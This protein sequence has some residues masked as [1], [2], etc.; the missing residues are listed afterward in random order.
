METLLISIKMVRRYVNV[1]YSL[2]YT[3]LCFV[4]GYFQLCFRTSPKKNCQAG[5]KLH[6][7][8]RADL[9]TGNG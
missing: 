9:V 1:I 4:N 7:I 3:E 6:P 5:T 8:S 2:H